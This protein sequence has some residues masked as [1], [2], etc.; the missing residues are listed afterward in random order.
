MNRRKALLTTSVLTLAFGVAP[1]TLWVLRH[2]SSLGK[3]SAND[4]SLST[5]QV[6]SAA[7]QR[8]DASALDKI[9]THDDR[10]SY[11]G[12]VIE[13]F[14]AKGEESWFATLKKGNKTLAKFEGGWNKEWT[15]FG[16]F[17]FIGGEP[18]QL[19]VEQYSG[20]AHCCYSYW[21]Y[22]LSATPRLVF[23]NG[24][25][26]TGNQLLPV[27][28]DGDGAFEL[29]HSVMAFDYFHMSHASSVFPQ[30]LFAYDKKAG[31]YR[32]ANQRLQAYSLAGIESDIKELEM[33]KAQ[34]NP[35]N[36]D[37]YSER[38]FSA[39]LQVTLK[40]IYAGKRDEGWSFFNREYRTHEG[41]N[42]EKMRAEVGET[43]REEPVYKYIYSKESQ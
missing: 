4:L 19:V 43:L 26:G 13:K 16:L 20:G 8:D 27:D 25:Y 33:L 34:G 5:A 28:I 21:I 23:D 2:R 17:P 30:A 35:D 32:P 22:D 1:A 3:R 29:K 42:K 40:Y 37:I 10:L 24:K 11:N 39:V 12:Y 18:K 31:E 15:N 36:D 14:Q 6:V 7:E 9:Y 38:Y 41:I